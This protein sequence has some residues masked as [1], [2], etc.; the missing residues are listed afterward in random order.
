[1]EGIILNNSTFLITGGTGSW[2]L[3]IVKQLINYKPKE[4]RI[5]SRNETTIC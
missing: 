1:M 5:F 4:I 2:G 3:E